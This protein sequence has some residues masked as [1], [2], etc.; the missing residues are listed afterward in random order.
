LIK[1]FVLLNARQY[2]ISATVIV[3]NACYNYR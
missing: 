3:K 2:I 1:S